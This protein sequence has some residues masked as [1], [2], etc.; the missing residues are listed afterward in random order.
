MREIKASA[1]TKMLHTKRQNLHRGLY[2]FQ[3]R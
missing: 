2:A 3:K 1:P